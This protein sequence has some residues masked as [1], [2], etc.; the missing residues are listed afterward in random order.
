MGTPLCDASCTDQMSNT[1]TVHIRA[2]FTNFSAEWLEQN[3]TV[4]TAVLLKE[5][6]ERAEADNLQVWVFVGVCVYFY[7]HICGWVWSWWWSW[8]CWC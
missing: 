7:T 6:L 8:W 3:P 5:F 4:P 1:L 2:R